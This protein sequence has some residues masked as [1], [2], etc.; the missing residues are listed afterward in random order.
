MLAKDI[1]KIGGV[2]PVIDFIYKNYEE[3][4]TALNAAAMY[5]FSEIYRALSGY[6][7][8]NKAYAKDIRVIYLLEDDKI[9]LD[10]FI[11]VDESKV[12]DEEILS[13][14]SDKNDV[15]IDIFK[16]FR[17]NEITIESMQTESQKKYSI[18]IDSEETSVKFDLD[19]KYSFIETPYH[20]TW[21]L[22]LNDLNEV[23]LSD[24]DLKQIE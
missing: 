24:D 23:P 3:H 9:N 1:T 16:S 15:V 13:N 12:T 6:L 14:L 19:I 2:K 8:V 10:N 7:A 17:K 21:N 11:E 5:E 20:N 18:L 4:K 22:Y